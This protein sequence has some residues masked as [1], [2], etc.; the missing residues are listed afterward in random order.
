MCL[1]FGHGQ[2]FCK[3]GERKCGNCADNIHT[4]R[5]KGEKCNKAPRC[6]NCGSKDHGSFSKVCNIYK[7]EQEISAIRVNKKIPY[8][9]AKREFM[10]AHPLRQ[11]SFAA[12]VR[13]KPP[14][15]GLVAVHIPEA[16]GKPTPASR[17]QFSA[18]KERDKLLWTKQHQMKMKSTK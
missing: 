7:M 9:N 4:D 10:A 11:R 16:S 8:G 15:I 6:V 3:T 17:D 13:M 5:E 14:D 12:A 2:K 1:K 18:T